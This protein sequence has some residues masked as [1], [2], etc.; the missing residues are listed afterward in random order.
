M[1]NTN[2]V[3]LLL[4]IKDAAEAI[5]VSERT[6][7]R[8]IRAGRLKPVYVTPDTPRISRLALEEFVV[9]MATTRCGAEVVGSSSPAAS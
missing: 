7:Y 1:N 5:G 6:L 2:A 9:A 8:L 3:R 4:T